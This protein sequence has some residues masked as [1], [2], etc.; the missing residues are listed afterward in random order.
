[1]TRPAS[2][3]FL[4]VCMGN[5][6]RSP[7]VEAVARVEFAKAGFDIDVASAGTESYHIG[8]PADRRTIALAEANGYPMAQHR[9]RQVLAEDFTRYDHL[10][11]MDRVNL[12][13]LLERT[14]ADARTRVD[15]FL[16]FAG[17]ESVEELPDPYYGKPADFARALELSR[18]GIDA[19]VRRLRHNRN[20]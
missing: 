10:L 20:G 6:C 17:V 14:P 19:L 16:P 4:F 3:S 2:T 9:A 1:M 5:I 7:T 12:R 15:L 11:V 18:H 13:A 8:D